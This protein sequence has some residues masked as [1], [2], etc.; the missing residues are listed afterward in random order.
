VLTGKKIHRERIVVGKGSDAVIIEI[1]K[2]G[3]GLCQIGNQPSPVEAV[4]GDV[5][6]RKSLERGCHPGQIRN[7]KMT[8]RPAV[9]CTS[10]NGH[11]KRYPLFLI[12]SSCDRT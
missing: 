2:Q 4:L 6:I 1:G 5:N 11:C 7:R 9:S 8:F 3:V 12:K 10:G